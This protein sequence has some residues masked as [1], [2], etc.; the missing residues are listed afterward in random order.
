[1]TMRVLER[2][3]V[4][5]LLQ[6]SGILA[7]VERA[8]R[9]PGLFVLNY[10]RVGTTAGNPLDDATFSATRRG[11]PAADV[12]P[13]ALVRPAAGDRRS[14]IAWRAGGSTNRRP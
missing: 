3:L 6:S 14:W 4:A 13:E 9:E 10:H 1:M 11:P 12:V 8:S 7:V 2:P 5:S